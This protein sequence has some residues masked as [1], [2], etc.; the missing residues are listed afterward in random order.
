[1]EEARVQKKI[2][3]DLNTLFIMK[4]GFEFCFSIFSH[5]NLGRVHRSLG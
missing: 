4:D 2:Y 5:V 3:I 1:M